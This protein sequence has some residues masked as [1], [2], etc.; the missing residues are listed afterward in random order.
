MFYEALEDF[1][2][3]EYGTIIKGQMI[4]NLSGVTAKDWCLRKM[5]KETKSKTA[6]LKGDKG[7]VDE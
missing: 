6:P 7:G 2:S 1:E 4:D 3:P 5:I